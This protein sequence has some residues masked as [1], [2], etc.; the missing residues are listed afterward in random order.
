MQVPSWLSKTEQKMDICDHD[1]RPSELIPT[2]FSLFCEF[3]F[4]FSFYSFLSFSTLCLL[5][6]S[7]N[8]WSTHSMRFTI[9]IFSPELPTQLPSRE[10]YFLFRGMCMATWDWL[11]RRESEPLP[12][13]LLWITHC[14]K[15]CVTPLIWKRFR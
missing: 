13:P 10:V 8:I 1:Q 12:H 7:L 11:Q 15:L 2:V 9:L 6:I 4:C 14:R 5:S 3:F